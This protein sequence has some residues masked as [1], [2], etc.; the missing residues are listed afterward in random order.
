MQMPRLKLLLLIILAIGCSKK[1]KIENDDPNKKDGVIKTYRPNGQLLSE[2]TMKDGKRNGISRRYYSNDTVSLEV[3]Y[4]DDKM[5]GLY[6]QYYEDGKPMKEIEYKDDQMDGLNKK[7]RKEGGQAWQAR[8]S[9]NEP[10]LGLVEYYLN[11]T[12]KTSY[13]YIVFETVDRLRQEGYFVLRIRMS[14]NTTTVSFYEGNLSDT[15]CFNEKLASK[16]F[17]RDKGIA[18]K[19]Y[20]LIPGGF[21]MEEIHVIAI[22]KTA[23]SNSYITTSHYNLAINN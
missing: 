18:I 9:M 19:D 14:D 13:P 2:V 5:N 22:V 3:Y 11:G 16:L 4:T 1:K 6:K 20:H 10:C 7:F 8:F 15:G 23:Q 12:Q 17:M 21:V